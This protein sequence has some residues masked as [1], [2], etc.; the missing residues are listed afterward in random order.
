MKTRKTIVYHPK[1]WICTPNSFL[2]IVAF[3]FLFLIPN[4]AMSQSV[5]E[6][7]QKNAFDKSSFAAKTIPTLETQTC[8]L[9]VTPANSVTN[10]LASILQTLVDSGITVSNI[11]TTLPAN[12]D[13]YGSFTCGTAAIG[14]ESGLIVTTG[15]INNALGPNIAG[16]ASR[17]NGLPGNALLNTLASPGFDASVISFDISSVSN[18]ISFRFVF[19]S[20]EYNEYV[21]TQFNDVFGFFVSGPGIPTPINIAKIPGTLTPVAIN[22]VNLGANPTYYLD[23]S[24]AGV[25]NPVRFAQL[26][27]D[28]L[29][30]VLIATINVTP[31]EN[32]TL[33]LGVQDVGD[34]DLDSGFFIEE[35]SITSQ[36]LFCP[37]DITVDATSGQCGAI[38]NFAASAASSP[39][40]GIPVITYSHQPGTNFNVG[41]TTVTVT[42]V[43]GCN[44]TSTCNFTVTVEDNEVPTITVSDVVKCYE[45]DSLGCN[46]LLGA[47]AT[48]NCAIAS[49]TS[50]APACFPIG[51]TTITWTATDVNGKV[52]TANQLV[53]RHPQL[54]AVC[55]GDI[56]VACG[57]NAADA[58]ATWITGFSYT[59]GSP[60]ATATDL[61]QYQMPEPGVTL[62]IT[63]TAS[64]N[65]ESDSCTATFLISPCTSIAGLCTY[66]QG[67]YGSSG[68][69]MCD[70]SNGNLTTAEMI[71]KCIANAGGTITVGMPG[72][73]VVMTSAAPN[74]VSCIIAKLPG[75]GTPTEI[76]A[77][78]PNICSLPN[79]YLKNGRIKNVLLSQTITL[80]L[81][82]NISNALNLRGFIL[83]AG[84]LVTAN[85]LGGCGSTLPKVRVCGH[86]DEFGVWVNTVNEYIYKSI[87]T[88]V[89]NAIAPNGSGD[90]TVGGLIDLANR[91]LANTDGIIGSENGV[92]LSAINDAVDTI[93]N[94]FDGC[95]IFIGWN[96]LPCPSPLAK[97]SIES[98]STNGIAMTAHPN[99]YKDNVSFEI[100]SDVS[101]KA[102]LEIFNLLGQRVTTD[103]NTSVEA[104]RPHKIDLDASKLNGTLIYV[105]T[106]GDKKVTGKLIKME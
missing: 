77:G 61:S 82:V 1:K 15:S 31:G 86:Y 75:G 46:V 39:G 44:N 97:I 99:P 21:G 62:V 35:G 19:S 60:N 68:G 14:I 63:Y 11:S 80:S 5:Y 65:C 24:S 49:L 45:E 95:K 78:N 25:A 2:P 96:V 52:A 76:A 23:N 55:S 87:T 29:T 85:P 41:T 10:S 17:I 59:G 67:A 104:G 93:N 50:D 12:S 33:R 69:M 66:S 83:H 20:E 9:S 91:A 48:D 70:G 105:L 38:V 79:S 16:N 74:S 30:V 4:S 56:V 27:H 92:S 42:A 81:N 37:D 98:V 13:I 32:Y 73:S 90:K 58:F 53:T 64:N 94:A 43:D 34:S 6:I 40:C 84:T 72:R 28:G 26:E 88:S 3:L 89:V 100:T 103:I 102:T 106:I 22:N 51:D 8:V 101:G 36:Q 57:E 18:S 7:R 47:T 54:V 71:E